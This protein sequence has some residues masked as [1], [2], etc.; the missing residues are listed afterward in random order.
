MQLKTV[1]ISGE[2][3]KSFSVGQKVLS[4]GNAVLQEDQRNNIGNILSENTAVYIRSY[5]ANTLSSMSFR[6]TSS[7]QSSIYWNGINISMPSIGSTDLSMVPTDYFSNASIVFGGSSVRYGSGAIGGGVFLSS[8]AIFSGKTTASA[9]MNAGSYASFGTS[10]MS[11]TSGEKYYFKIA[12]NANESKNDYGYV[13]NR[14]E[15]QYLENAAFSGLGLNIHAAGRIS[16]NNQLDVFLWYQEA[17]REIPPTTS[18]KSSDAYQSDR[19][20][21]ASVQW[22]TFLRN[23]ILNF[24]TAWF[25]EYENYT[26]PEISLQSTILTNTGFL[27][28]EYRHR[29]SWNASMDAGMSMK[30]EEA[31]IAAYGGVEERMLFAAFI[32]YKQ[33]FHKINWDFLAGARQEFGSEA[34]APFTPAIGIEGPI[35]SYLSQ[36]LSISRNYRMPTMN[37]MFWQP[38]GKPDI[39]PE[40]SWNAEFSMI[41]ELLKKRDDQLLSLTATLY[42]SLVDNWILWLPQGNIWTADNIQTVWA[43]GVEFE[44]QYRIEG[45]DKHAVFSLSYTY[46]KSTNEADTEQGNT[47]GKQLIY[48]P[49]NNASGK[50]GLGLRTWSFLLFGRYS[51]LSYLTS[52]NSTSLPGFFVADAALKKYFDTRKIK[53]SLSARVNNLFNK[54]YY[55]VAYRPMP[56]R[57]FNISISFTFKTLQN[58]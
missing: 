15:E 43:R 14:G 12:F 55:V 50:L 44:T 33:H 56:G 34:M 7:N 45:I 51:G 57:N 2:R 11:S 10:I 19:A 5:G 47:K 26:D 6:G 46:S 13:T 24:K 40:S 29:F 27:E 32:N 23:G 36:K 1:S 35:F 28:T 3:Y 22:K 38:G 54:D 31:D 4:L 25:N 9:N 18:M 48:T 8:Q 17:L 30:A 37:E 53:I 52:D 16:K 41:S 58:D 21:R 20:T 39:L 49:L 42:S